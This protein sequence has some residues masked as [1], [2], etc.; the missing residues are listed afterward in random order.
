MNKKINQDLNEKINQIPS[1]LFLSTVAAGLLIALTFLHEN[2]TVGFFDRLI[3]SGFFITSCTLGI[4]LTARPGLF[5]I[6]HSKQGIAEG[7]TR[8]QQLQFKGHHP[9]CIHFQ[10]HVLS[11]RKKTLCAGCTGLQIG[12]IAAI[13][14]IILYNVTG[15]LGEKTFN[16]FIG[17]IL[18]GLVYIETILSKRQAMLHVIFNLMLVVAFLL[19]TIGVLEL[20]KASGPGVISILLSFLWLDTRIRLSKWRHTMICRNCGKC[21][22]FIYG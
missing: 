10:S 11:F 17:F 1:Y 19:I 14:L 8:G 13:F 2:T 3:V 6:R 18:I 7:D 5:K 21:K 15:S 16:L 4:L 9:G 20:T 22:P 12:S